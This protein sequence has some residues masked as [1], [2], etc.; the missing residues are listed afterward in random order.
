MMPTGRPR[1][2]ACDP[3]CFTVVRVVSRVARGGVDQIIHP[4]RGG[5]PNSPARRG[6]DQILHPGGGVDQI[7]HPDR[8]VDLILQKGVPPLSLN[9]P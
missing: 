9:G 2:Y 8:G 3:R 6:V 7:L 1:P 5:R 4:D